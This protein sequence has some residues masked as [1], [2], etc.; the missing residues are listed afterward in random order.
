MPRDLVLYKAL[1]PALIENKTYI[2]LLSLNSSSKYIP[3]MLSTLKTN[4][5]N[6]ETDQKYNGLDK[7][8][9]ITMGIFISIILGSDVEEIAK[10]RK[11]YIFP[12]DTVR[13]L[14]FADLFTRIIIDYTV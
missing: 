10:S 2:K 3:S 12:D 7:I 11:P 5:D 4:L 9:E 6:W 14:D 1:S 13:H 8:G